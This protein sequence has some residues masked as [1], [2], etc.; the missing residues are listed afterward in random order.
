M[1]SE[2][3]KIKID[4]VSVF[5]DIAY[6]YILSRSNCDP[7]AASTLREYYT[8]PYFLSQDMESSRTDW[9]FMGTPGYGAHM[10]VCIKN[11]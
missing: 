5:C 4:Y 7:E 1:V 8:R 2:N 3:R 6:L 10:H 11:Y 9:I